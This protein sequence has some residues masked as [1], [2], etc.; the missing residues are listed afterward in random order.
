[1]AVPQKKGTHREDPPIYGNP[2]LLLWIHMR[3]AKNQ[4]PK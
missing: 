3:V 1:M 4:G 2:T